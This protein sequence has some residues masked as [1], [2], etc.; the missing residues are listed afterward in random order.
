MVAVIVLRELVITS[1]RSF[2]ETAG[3]KFGAD[4]LGKIKMVLQCAALLAIFILLLMPREPSLKWTAV[5]WLT[6]A[7]VYGT[8]V[9]TLCSGVQYIW[10]AVYIFGTAPGA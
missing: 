3:A 6:V 8:V 9:T 1:L 7:L 10:R 4:W 2:M 5:Y